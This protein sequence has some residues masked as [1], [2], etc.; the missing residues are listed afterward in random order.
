MDLPPDDPYY[1]ADPYFECTES[2]DQFEPLT[3]DTLFNSTSIRHGCSAFKT[4]APGSTSSSPQIISSVAITTDDTWLSVMDEACYTPYE[5][6]APVLMKNAPVTPSPTVVIDATRPSQSPT[7]L[8]SIV[9]T[10][11]PPTNRPALPTPAP[12]RVP[13]PVP[14]RAPILT[15]EAT[16]T[17][18]GQSTE[19][20]ND[21]SGALIGGVVGGIGAAIVIGSLIGFLVCRRK[22]DSG[23]T[24]KSE[25]GG[26]RLSFTEGT[27]G[28][29]KL[30][31]PADV[32]ATQQPSHDPVPPASLLATQPTT[33]SSPAFVPL[34]NYEVG[35][36]DQ[37]RTVIDAIPAVAVS[38]TQQTSPV[39]PAPLSTT[40]PTSSLPAS[41]PSTNYEVGYKDQ[42]RTV[43]ATIPAVAAAEYIPVPFAVALDMS[44]ASGESRS[45]QRSEPPGRFHE[46]SIACLTT[47]TTSFVSPLCD[48]TI[49]PVSRNG[50][51]DDGAMEGG[52]TAIPIMVELVE[53]PP[54][55]LLLLLL[56]PLILIPVLLLL[57]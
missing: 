43:I 44:A 8:L 49:N 54:P 22:A 12:V 2:T 28:H 14:A 21:N 16:P 33:S 27:D 40:Q 13:T 46:L 6:A 47:R 36:K 35:Y 11:P 42:T 15:R 5:S 3:D 32:L 1:F 37:T 18:T 19:R 7:L 25:V 45:S 29:D 53:R 51:V 20:S 23:D 24:H 57:T 50:L 38:A 41:I 10:S 9:L 30:L 48:T 26:A 17:L 56:L 55:T 39:P 52:G 34:T 4:F 31:G